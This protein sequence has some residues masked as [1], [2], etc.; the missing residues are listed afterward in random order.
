MNDCSE[1]HVAKPLF[2]PKD[3]GAFF[4]AD[5]LGDVVGVDLDGHTLVAG[6]DASHLDAVDRVRLGREL[7]ERLEDHAA[8]LDGVASFAAGRDGFDARRQG[9]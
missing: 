5:G 4:A 6:L 1:I 8:G 3:A 2:I 9:D 7:G